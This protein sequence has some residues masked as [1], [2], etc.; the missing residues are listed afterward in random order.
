[1][2]M[3]WRAVIGVATLAATLSGCGEPTHRL[4]G[5]FILNDPGVDYRESSCSG[6][7]EHADIQEGLDVT[8]TDETGKIVGSTELVYDS[9][10]SAGQCLFTWEMTVGDAKSYS[11]EVGERA[12]GVYTA[13][14][15]D[16]RYWQIAF[17][18]GD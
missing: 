9:R 5:A 18:V 11:I 13:E 4:L 17:T 8:A 14:D 12:A 7:G 1:M 3:S 6:R 16:R 15:L 10:S 2:R